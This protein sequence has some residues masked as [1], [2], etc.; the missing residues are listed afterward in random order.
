MIGKHEPRRCVQRGSCFQSFDRSN[1]CEARA[2]RRTRAC[3]GHCCP[4]SWGSR[5]TVGWPDGK[6]RAQ[7][8]RRRR[9]VGRACSWHFSFAGESVIFGGRPNRV[10][11]T[12]TL[13]RAAAPGRRI[14]EAGR[15]PGSNGRM[16]GKHEPR[17][18]SARLVFSDHFDRSNPCE[19]RARRRTR[20]CVPWQELRGLRG[21]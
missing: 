14:C 5:F 7:T 15:R 18:R 11:A 21:L 8:S 12:C 16:I 19:A 9:A 2:R 6:P 20:A 4:I 13:L 1:P 3:G 10:F 17:R